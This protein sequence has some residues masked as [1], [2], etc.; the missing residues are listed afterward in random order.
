MIGGGLQEVAAVEVAQSQGYNIIVTDRNEEAPCRES[1]DEFLNMDGENVE[2]IISFVKKNKEKLDIVGIFTLTELVYSVAAVANQCGIPGVSV[3]A[4]IICQDK[5]LSKEKWL[6]DSVST[7]IG[8]VC[9]TYD[10]VLNLFKELEDDI[11]VKPIKGFGG[12]G[13]KRITTEEGLNNFFKKKDI[14][15]FIIEEF[16]SGPMIDVNGFF[17][18]SGKFFSLGC[19]DRTFEKDIV[20]ETTGI[21]PSQMPESIQEEAYDLTMKAGLSLGIKWGPIKSDLVLTSKGL[22]VLEI[23]PRLHGPKGTLFLT[24]LSGGSDHF[25]SILPLLEGLEIDVKDIRSPEYISGFRLIEAPSK[26]FKS[27]KGLRRLK[28]EGFDAMIFKN[29]SFVSIEYKKSS[30]AIGYVFASSAND[31]D[32]KAKLDYANSLIKF[33]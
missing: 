1:A 30:D 24:K 22:K 5:C 4:A 7:P 8:D 25:S 28:D 10:Q 20:I 2:D 31:Q 27:I 26:P 15:H 16:C 18:T 11:F 12:I 19:F 17:N 14:E 23:A 21:Y 29:S 3:N 13:A 33:N 9:K 32:L 6:N